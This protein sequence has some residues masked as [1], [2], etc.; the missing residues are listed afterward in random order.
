MARHSHWHQIRLKKGAA[1]VKRGKIFTRHGRLIE[2]AAR[3]SGGDPG[4]NPGLA[5]MIENA[6][7]D[8]M[9][10]ENI[11][12]A[13]KKG[14]GEGKDAVQ[15]EEVVY[16]GF[17]PGGVALM[18][19]TLTDNKNRTF[20]AVRTIITKTG[21]TMGSAG[22][23]S[24]LFER[25]GEIH[26]K[27]KGARDDDELEIIDAG[28]QDL[29]ENDVESG[30]GYTVYT[31]PNELAVVR[32]RLLEK[33]FTLESQ[34]LSYIPLNPIELSDEATGEKMMTL[35]DALDED[36]DVTNVAAALA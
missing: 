4:M 19:E 11:D 22:A 2:M 34:K 36:E 21:G 33:G 10:R 24:F 23:T 6:R 15:Y 3:R 5:T 28:A 7:A 29:I 16:E 27:A 26:V 13:I 1:D 9:P 18:I 12:R 30:G 31:H 20:Q 14:T 35:L 17:G 32:T 25:K 8:N